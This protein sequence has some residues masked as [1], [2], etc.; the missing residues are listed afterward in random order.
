MVK[1]KSCAAENVHNI[2]LKLLK[3]ESRGYVLDAATG[4]GNITYNLLKMGFDVKPCDIDTKNF[5]LKNV[6]CDKVDLNGKLPYNDE[7]FDYVVSVET[8]EHLENPWG[9]IREF[10]RVMKPKGTLILTTPNVSNIFSRKLFLTKCDFY[11]FENY[12]EHIT[13]L[14]FPLLKRI[15]NENGFIIEN[16]YTNKILKPLRFI[17]VAYLIYPFIQKECRNS[18][19][20]F[21][22]I[23]IIKAKKQI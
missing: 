18:T 15:L 10:Y 3:N 22:D 20:L 7:S 17:I 4:E 14:P 23:L 8:I 19:I 6:K 21:G 1:I 13:P 5:K 9:V 12:K 11:R 2:V 16:V